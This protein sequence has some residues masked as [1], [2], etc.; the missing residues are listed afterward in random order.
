VSTAAGDVD[1]VE[2]QREPVHERCE[3]QRDLFSVGRPTEN[4]R[5]IAAGLTLALGERTASETPPRNRTVTVR[6]CG[7]QYR[8]ESELIGP[9]TYENEWIAQSK[10]YYESLRVSG[11]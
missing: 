8:T 3:E 11:A 9:Q 2:Q 4:F 10:R 1:A 5:S 7:P 6:F